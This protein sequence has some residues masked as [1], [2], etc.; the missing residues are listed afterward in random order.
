MDAP[1]CR[2]CSKRHYGLC[3]TTPITEKAAP[4]QKS[5]DDALNV[6]I[7]AAGFVGDAMNIPEVD[8][9]ELRAVYGKMIARRTYMRKYMQDRREKQRSKG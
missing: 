1:K 6:A 4:V 2:L 5:V 3:K 9:A 8:D 7:E